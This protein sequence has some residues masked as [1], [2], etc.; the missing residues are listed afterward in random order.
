RRSFPSLV[1]QCGKASL[2]GQGGGNTPVALAVQHECAQDTRPLALGR[3]RVQSQRFSHV[4]RRNERGVSRRLSPPSIPAP[5]GRGAPCP[6]AVG[7]ASRR[8]HRREG[9]GL[10]HRSGGRA[11][12]CP[13]GPLRARALPLWLPFDRAAPHLSRPTYT[14]PW[15]RHQRHRSLAVPPWL[16]D[17]PA[18]DPCRPHL[19]DWPALPPLAALPI[20]A[21][22]ANIKSFTSEV[23]MIYEFRTYTLHPRTLSEFIKRWT[24]MI[25]KRQTYSK[26]A[27]FWYTE[28]GPLN[29]VIHV[30]PY[31]NALERSKIR[32]AVVKDKVWPPPTSECIAEMRSEIYEPL[33]FAPPMEPSN[34]GPYFEMRTYTLKPGSIADM[35]RRWKEHLPA[36]IKLSPLTGVFTSD[37]GGLNQWLHI[38]A[39]KSLD[40][41]AEVRKKAV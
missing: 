17:K 25:D 12:F 36:R 28:I 26:L 14:L 6:A 32:A 23:P 22:D 3:G 8:S 2:A 30:W 5:P 10:G 40:Q 27:A 33:P 4:R 19:A 7:A 41:R 11:S 24:D 13:T 20:G 29:Q 37:V 18:R 35:A 16:A 34:D 39:Y 38:W 1:P 21:R 9:L 31:E 15:R